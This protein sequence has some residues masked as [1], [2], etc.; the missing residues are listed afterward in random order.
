LS[1]IPRALRDATADRYR[2]ERELGRGGMATVYLAHDLK[3]GRPVAIKVMHPELAA[4]IGHD[5]F[6]R[7]IEI[8]ARLTHP[9]ILPLHD[10]GAADTQ[11]YYVMPYIE[12]ESLRARLLREKQLPVEDALRLTR[13]IAS[14]LGLAHHHGLVHRDVK[15][16]NVLLS[17]G[18][19]LVADFGIARAMSTTGGRGLTTAGRAIGTP[20]YMAPEQAMGNTDVDGRA[21]LYALGCVLYEMLAGQPPF[22]GRAD[23]LVYQHLNAEPRLVTELRPSVPAGVAA[24]IARALA[25]FPADR[26][27]TMARFAE[28]LAVATTGAPTPTPRPE[29]ETG[30]VPNNLPRQRTRF[31]GREKELA[32]C[33]RLMGDTRL[34]TLA[35]IGGCGKT[36]LALRLAENLLASFPDGVWFVDL[37]P[38]KDA[39]RVALTVATVLGVPEQPGAPLADLL[40]RHLQS[41]RALLVLDNCEH[42]LD[43]AAELADTLLGA[44]ADL[45]LIAT[46]REGL[47]IDGERIVSLRS[48]SVPPR[49]EAH[50]LA[51]VEASEAVRLFVDRAQVVDPQFGLSEASAGPVAEICRRLDGIPLAIELAAARVRV[52]SV[53]EICARL[54]DRFRLL[55]GGSKTALP[56]HQTLRATIQWSFDQLAP[57]EQQLFRVFSVFAGGWTLAAATRVAG[58]EADE[59]EVLDAITRLVDK[60]LVTMERE[61]AGESRYAMLETVRQYA[62]EQLNA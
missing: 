21:D 62:Q 47:G 14:A 38:L 57:Q 31:I 8:A 29:P 26:Y 49:A 61:V 40:V 41:Q 58:P 50:T 25:K 11:L 6:L 18:I 4:A 28:A 34:L 37:A 5:R 22:T 32:E 39:H 42:V 54:D 10:S 17:D 33:A 3:Y 60:S 20:A 55:T 45:K 43:P 1:E 56:R 51:T 36:R 13:E 46:S 19:A 48:L 52:L 27:P 24:A 12:G 35:G 44:C 7:E 23:S 2:I 9:H 53:E 30:A 59:F 15:P 16:E